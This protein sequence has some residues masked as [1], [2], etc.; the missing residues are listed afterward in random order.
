MVITNI[1]A[2]TFTGAKST[3]GDHVSECTSTPRHSD[4][5]HKLQLTHM[6]SVHSVNL[7]LSMCSVILMYVIFDT[8]TAEGVS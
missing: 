3:E 6:Q 1:R 8:H 4:P 7:I 2:I 5:V